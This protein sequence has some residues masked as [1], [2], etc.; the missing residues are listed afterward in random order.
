VRS[1]REE[2]D[3]AEA[4]EHLGRKLAKKLAEQRCCRGITTAARP[5]GQ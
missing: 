2:R 3:R 4:A 5:L 1:F